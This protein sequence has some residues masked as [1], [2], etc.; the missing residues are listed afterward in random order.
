MGQHSLEPDPVSENKITI[1]FELVFN[2]KYDRLFVP[3]DPISGLFNHLVNN[4]VHGCFLICDLD[5]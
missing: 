2:I 3:P 4:T 1:F 5:L